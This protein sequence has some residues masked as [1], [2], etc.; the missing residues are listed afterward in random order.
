MDACIKH[1]VPQ[2]LWKQDTPTVGVALEAI[3]G[4]LNRSL[5]HFKDMVT[6]KTD[7]KKS[8]SSGMIQN[9]GVSADRTKCI[10]N[11]IAVDTV[12]AT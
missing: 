11:I 7:H 12:W 3:L 1:M 5:L 8:S 10:E 2:S 6:S 4:L 9:A